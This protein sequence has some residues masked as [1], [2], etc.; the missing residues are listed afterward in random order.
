MKAIPEHLTKRIESTI[1]KYSLFSEQTIYVSYSGGKDSFFLC[2]ALSQLGYQVVPVTIDI[3]FGADWS[4]ARNNL[5]RLGLDFLLLDRSYVDSYFP[6][7]GNI[8]DGNMELFRQA[9]EGGHVKAT[10]CT[11]CYNSKMMVLKSWAA[12]NGITEIAFG[13]HGTDAIASLLKSFYMYIDRW[14]HHNEEFDRNR[15]EELVRSDATRYHSDVADFL[16]SDLYADIQRENSRRTIGTDEP[17]KQY[18]SGSNVV[19][20]RP[21]YSIFEDEIR[22]CYSD[23]DLSIGQSECFS[24]GM[25]L[26]GLRTPRELIQDYLLTDANLD[27]LT[28]LLQVSL[29]AIDSNGYLLYNVR[30]QRDEIL[31]ASYKSTLENEK[32]L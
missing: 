16:K 3:G 13:H 6:D 4:L 20:C 11:Y 22:E 10:V 12:K 25:R 24:T 31:G 23:L 5:G 27:V 1:Q 14:Y 15:F 28:I 7:L 18:I 2:A 8:I 17:V 21:M 30:N 29:N 32:K 26:K 9:N 19:I